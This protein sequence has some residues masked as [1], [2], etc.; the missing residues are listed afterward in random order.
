MMLKDLG[1]A[2]SVFGAHVSVKNTLSGQDREIHPSHLGSQ[3]P[4]HNQGKSDRDLATR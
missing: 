1:R 2:G 3:L 4:P